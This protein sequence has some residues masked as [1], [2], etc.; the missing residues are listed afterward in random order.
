MKLDLSTNL[1]KPTRLMW[2]LSTVL[3][4]TGLAWGFQ[5]DAD[6]HQHAFYLVAAA[7]LI[8]FMSS[9]VKIREE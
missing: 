8:L 6:V 5:P 2:L 9:V 1:N 4:F 7:F 3:G